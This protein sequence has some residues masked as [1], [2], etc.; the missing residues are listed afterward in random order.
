MKLE[1]GLERSEKREGVEA[2]VI[3][4]LLKLLPYKGQKRYRTVKF[5]VK[6]SSEGFFEGGEDMG[7]RERLKTRQSKD[8]RGDNLL[9]EM[10]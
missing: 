2:S 9:E 7:T 8:D 4:N 3:D 10:G 6:R 1:A 5:P